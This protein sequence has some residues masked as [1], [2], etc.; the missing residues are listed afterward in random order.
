M[1]SLP[2]VTASSAEAERRGRD[3][4]DEERP[5][6]LAVAQRRSPAG[7]RNAGLRY[8]ISEPTRLSAPPT[9]TPTARRN[10]AGV[11]AARIVRIS[12]D[13]RVRSR[14]EDHRA[15]CG[16][17]RPRDRRRAARGA[18]RHGDR[19]RRRS[20]SRRSPAAST[21]RT[22][23]G[24]G[25]TQAGPDARPASTAS[26]LFIGCSPREEANL[27]CAMLVKRCRR[28]QTI[29]R[30]TSAAYLEAWRERQ[31]DVDFMVSPGARDGE[32]DLGR[33]SAC[34][35]R[36]TPTCS[37]TARSRSS[38]STCRADAARRTRCIGRA[39]RSAA[40]PADS[41]R[42]GADPRRPLCRAARRRADPAAATASW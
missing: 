32:R 36:A 1:R 23:E 25:T 28:A 39:L 42:G 7:N 12:R 14:H 15:G 8:L 37:P 11:A 31:I 41:T 21:S 20:G 5:H 26:D 4:R 22:V 17:R 16:Q 35:P 33:S 24:D 3:A 30:T 10:A 40:I 27:V 9:S 38:S 6:R 2:S 34:R 13:H 19:R 18:R 29:I